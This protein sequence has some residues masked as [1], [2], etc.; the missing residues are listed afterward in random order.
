MVERIVGST[1]SSSNVHGVVDNYSNYYRSMIIDAMR[2]NQDY[3]CKYS[4]VDE[5][6]NTYTTRF[7]KLLKD[8]DAPL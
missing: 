4:I 5:K 7:F 2:M 6:P 3:T 8:S 1:S